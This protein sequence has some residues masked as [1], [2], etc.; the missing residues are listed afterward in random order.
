VRNCLCVS[1]ALEDGRD[2]LKYCALGRY[3]FM[4]GEKV[5]V[6]TLLSIESTQI[7]S[8]FGN[9][10]GLVWGTDPTT[11][12]VPTPTSRMKRNMVRSTILI[13]GR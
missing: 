3:C 5:F 11:L 7:S 12:S 6:I 13:A 1:M 9:Y 2:F 10:L 8:V 4:F